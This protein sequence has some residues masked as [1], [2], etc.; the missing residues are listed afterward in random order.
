[1]EFFKIVT[2]RATIEGESKNSETEHAF[3]DLFRPAFSGLSS[4]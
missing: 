3:T 2:E 4:S 1:V